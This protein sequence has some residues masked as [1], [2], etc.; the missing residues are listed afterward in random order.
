[1]PVQVRGEPLPD[2]LGIAAPLRAAGGIAIVL[3]LAL[4]VA[5]VVLLVL[6]ARSGR[7]RI[8][9]IG[10]LAVW[11]AGVA[12][13]VSGAMLLA[14]LLDGDT[15]FSYVLENWHPDLPLPYRIAAFWAGPQ[16]SLLFWVILLLAA[17]AAPAAGAWR[18]LERTS[19]LHVG[20]TV[21]LCAVALVLVALLVFDGG[22]GPFVAAADPSRPPSGLNPLLIHP[23]MALHPPALFLGYVGLVVPFAYAVSALVAGRV[24]PAWASAAR[25][26][27]LA[28][29]VFLSL[30]IGLGAWWAYVILSWGGY[31]GWDPVENTSLVP[32]LTATA[33]L[34]A[35]SVYRTG[36]SF[37][38][39]AFVLA[40]LTFWCT[41]VAAWTTRTGVVASV[42]AFEQ[43]TLLLV[44]LSA[45]LSVVAVA[46]AALLV[47]RWRAIGRSGTTGD[48]RDG[49]AT[50][51]ARPL[52]REFLAVAMTLFSGA[53]LFATIVVP[54][55]F[56][57]T[58]R[59]ETYETLARPLGVAVVLGVGV[60]ALVGS[61]RSRASRDDTSNG[62][63]REGRRASGRRSAALWWGVPSA[64]GAVVAVL[65]AA[66]GAADSA[67]GLIGLSVCTFTA[68]ATLQ[69]LAR[70]WARRRGAG[71]GP[72]AALGGVLR[73]RTFGGALVHLG[74]VLVVAGLI[75]AGVYSQRQQLEFEPVANAM[76]T[77]DGYGFTLVGARVQKAPQGGERIIAEVTVRSDGRECGTVG[78]A[79]D[80]YADSGQTV[81]RA[82]ILG[83][84]WRD[85]FVSPVAFGEDGVVV[86]AIVFPLVRFIWIGAGLLVV[87][88]VVALWP[89]RGAKHPVA[90]AA[91][92]NGDGRPATAL[93]EPVA[94]ADEPATASDTPATAPDEE[95]GAEKEGGR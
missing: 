44:V 77:M 92:T 2:A 13:L 17:T 78:P 91:M 88:G 53:V 15:S 52:L 94:R 59:A 74:L 54:L 19:A 86:E 3:C 65:L 40:I 71:R 22:S 9:R 85:V 45:M 56:G 87:G 47:L 29:W 14:A 42:H 27:A 38:R 66:G 93:D 49:P 4:L 58:V 76:A 5:A 1:V 23:A 32:W 31:W 7:A 89:R 41:I 68:A 28:G 36:A 48:E 75:G 50:L 12:A 72:W 51:T 57:Q 62:K 73:G 95:P 69:W 35:L 6:G 83:S 8:G 46:G 26:W 24:G 37:R 30:G 34:H 10:L 33:L 90:A 55:V 18:N 25:P 63:R 79:L 82:D 60:C 11:G 39:W 16:G 21:V 70:L 84:S 43:R 67:V 80:Y 61:G 64:S 81:A 20:A